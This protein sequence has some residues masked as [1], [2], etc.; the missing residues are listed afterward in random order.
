MARQ[1]ETIKKE[2]SSILREYGVKRAAIFGSTARGDAK[3]DSDI[4]ILIEFDGSL[5]RL[6]SLKL[7][8][9]KKL[10]K[11]VDLVE[12]KAINPYLRKSILDN[13]VQI[14]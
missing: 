12:Y 3:K 1:T 9:E 10:R 5:F 7:A 14:L 8:L 2:A 13:Q 11:K 6:I 4:D